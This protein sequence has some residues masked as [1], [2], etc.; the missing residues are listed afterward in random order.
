MGL[1]GVSRDHRLAQCLEH[2]RCSIN[3]S[4][5]PSQQLQ[6]QEG[7]QFGQ[8]QHGQPTALE[9]DMNLSPYSTTLRFWLPGQFASALWVSVSL[10]AHGEW[11]SPISRLEMIP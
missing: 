8:P 9:A 3:G 7:L 5:L 1:L 10:S 6:Q 11:V 2:S 4:H